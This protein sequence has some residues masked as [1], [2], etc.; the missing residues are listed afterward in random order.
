MC[1]FPISWAYRIVGGGYIEGVT[2]Q[3]TGE[4]SLDWS[5]SE[6]KGYLVED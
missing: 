2:A 3:R 4:R 5:D 1:R 6:L